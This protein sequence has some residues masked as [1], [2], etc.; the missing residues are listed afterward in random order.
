MNIITLSDD[1]IIEILE[2]SLVHFKDSRFELESSGLIVKHIINLIRTG[3]ISN[4]IDLSNIFKMIQSLQE[5]VDTE[6]SKKGEYEKNV[7]KKIQDNFKKCLTDYSS[8]VLDIFQLRYESLEERVNV[9]QNIE[10][11]TRLVLREPKSPGRLEEEKKR[12]LIG[13]SYA[14]SSLINGIFRDSLQDCYAWERIANGKKITINEIVRK[15]I[16]DIY[17]HYKQVNDLIYFQGYD[18]I[19]K[20]SVEQSNFTYEQPSGKIIFVDL[21]YSISKQTGKMDITKN[22]ITQSLEEIAEK[23]ERIETLYKITLIL[24]QILMINSAIKIL[25]NRYP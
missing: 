9:Y 20:N 4:H 1:R 2:K 3:I 5:S 7:L 18:S 24:N 19:I 21:H 16:G 22:S 10:D 12:R 8:E 14:Y 11:L 13:L 25:S 15:E 17:N 6:F 23:Y